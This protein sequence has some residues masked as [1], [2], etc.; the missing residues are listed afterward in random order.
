MIAGFFLI[1]G[2]LGEGEE[3]IG[4]L[5]TVAV[6]DSVVTHCVVSDSVL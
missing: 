5:A 6:S 3:A 4:V 2:F 1:E